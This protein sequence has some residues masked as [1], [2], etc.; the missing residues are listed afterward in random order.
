FYAPSDISGVGGMHHEHIRAT[1]SW[2]RGPPCYDCVFIEHDPEAAGFRGLRAACV[3]LFFWFK[4]R[5]VD[6]PCALIHWFSA[7]DND[8]CPYTGMWIVAPD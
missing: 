3:W 7:R 4:F 1:K 2:Y 5:G 8:P 6:H